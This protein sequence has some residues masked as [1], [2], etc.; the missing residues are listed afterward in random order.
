MKL[1]TFCRMFWILVALHCKGVSIEK[2]GG[3]GIVRVD[4]G[5]LG[6]VRKVR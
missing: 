1:N 2:L 6:K 4:L 3:L 5:R